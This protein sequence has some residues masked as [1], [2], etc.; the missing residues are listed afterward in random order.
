MSAARKGYIMLTTRNAKI[1]DVEAI[2]QLNMAFGYEYPPEKTR[3]KLATALSRDDQRVILAVYEGQVI[4][5]IH[6]EDYDTLYFDHMK[7]VLG[8]IV[9][10]EY[11]RMGA[12][13][14]LLAA[15]DQW[16]RETGASGVRLDSGIEREPA[17]ACY[18]KNGY[19]V[20][21]LHK[22]FRKLF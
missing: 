9:F 15:A 11:R 21:K 12:A 17:H 6:L 5:Y 10:P 3:D 8:L 7:N 16:A 2:I 20:R 22:N 19:S 18:E 14:A 1:E 13:S 4:G